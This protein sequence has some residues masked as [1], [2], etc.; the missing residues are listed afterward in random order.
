M[1]NQNGKSP[2]EWIITIAVVLVIVGVAVAMIF[3]GNEDFLNIIKRNKNSNTAINT[4]VENKTYTDE[5][6]NIKT[7]NTVKAEQE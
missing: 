2:L 3:A 5:N 6:M 7:D 1:K 4:Q